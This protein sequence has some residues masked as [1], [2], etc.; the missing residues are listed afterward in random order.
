MN[1]PV[2]NIDECQNI[3]CS[4]CEKKL[5]I[6]PSYLDSEEVLYKLVV[7]CP[8]CGD[9]SFELDIRGPLKYYPAEN[10]KIK[11]FIQKGNLVRFVTSK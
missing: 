2:I 8:F 4:N 7:D 9:K 5:L 6:L 1:S 11:D 3:K 10:V